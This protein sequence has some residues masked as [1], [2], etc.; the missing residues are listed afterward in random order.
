MNTAGSQFNPIQWKIKKRKVFV[1]D[2]DIKDWKIN[3]G[4]V[5]TTLIYMKLKL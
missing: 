2:D 4:K 3:E 5:P 1:F